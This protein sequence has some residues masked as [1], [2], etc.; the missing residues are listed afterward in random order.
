MSQEPYV[1]T[2]RRP[3]GARRWRASRLAATWLVRRGV[4]PNAISVAGML[5]AIAAGG[6]LASTALSPTWGRAAWLAAAVLIL[7]RGAANMLDG[8]VAIESGRASR[9]GELFNELP[10]RVSDSA[11]L[12]G[13]GYAHGSEP[14]LGYVAAL[15]A[16]FT[17]YVRAMGKV[18]G[19]PQFYHGPMAKPHRMALVIALCLVGAVTPEALAVRIPDEGLA[20]PVWVLAVIAAGCVLTAGRRFL[21][22]RDALREPTG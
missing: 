5:C 21:A 3:L 7:L 19:A 16:L 8:M 2:D 12:I 18:A 13:L 14:T 10:D 22:I 1:P 9:L 11:L 4:S 20:P 17:A 15:L 6:L